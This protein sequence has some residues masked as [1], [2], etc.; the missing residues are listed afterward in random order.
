MQENVEIF[1]PHLHHPQIPVDNGKRT[2]Q[3]KQAFD[4]SVKEEVGDA[5]GCP[6]VFPLN[7]DH[8]VE[9]KGNHKSFGNKG[10]DKPVAQGPLELAAH[11]DNQDDLI[12]I[13]P[14]KRPDIG[15]NDEALQASPNRK[16]EHLKGSNF[17][18]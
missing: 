2:H 13:I 6:I 9:L 15:H 12:D 11:I 7:D 4:S 5:L 3:R 17:D 10:I 8:L 1:T 18:R 14:D 16:T